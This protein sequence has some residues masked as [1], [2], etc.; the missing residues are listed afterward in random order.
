MKLLVYYYLSQNSLDLDKPLNDGDII[1]ISENL[2][3]LESGT[4]KISGEVN[5]PGEYSILKGDTILDVINRA[6]GYSEDSYSEGAIF[7]RDE[8]A[9]LQK[10]GFERSAQTLENYLINIISELIDNKFLYNFFNKIGIQMHYKNLSVGIIN[11]ND[12]IYFILNIFLLIIIG[13]KSIKKTI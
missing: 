4:V 12:I 13:I 7:T 11:L 3:L 6:G 1:N 2:A 10:E 5:K 8:V 9:K